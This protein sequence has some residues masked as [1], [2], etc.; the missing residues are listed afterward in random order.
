MKQVLWVE[1]LARTDFGSI[2]GPVFASG[3]YDIQI[4]I[5]PTEAIVKLKEK[6]FAAVVIDI[7]LLPGNDKRWIDLYNKCGK[8]KALAQLGIHLAQSLLRFPDA[9]IILKDSEIPE[10]ITANHIAFFSVE[11]WT[12]MEHHLLT[13]GITQEA[14]I[15]KGPLN[16]RDVLLRLIDSVTSR[17]S[18]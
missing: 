10:W 2:F 13:L 9:Q 8:N 3:R 16:K 11:A 1:D 18:K 4:A 12:E 17:T 6:E 7:R 5:D 15:E 14:F